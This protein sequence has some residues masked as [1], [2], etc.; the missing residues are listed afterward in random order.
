MLPG[1]NIIEVALFALTAALGIYYI[2]STRLID[3][4]VSVIRALHG[5]VR[6]LLAVVVTLL[7]FVDLSVAE[8]TYDR[9]IILLGFFTIIGV[10]LKRYNVNP[11]VLL[12]SIILS[13]KLIWLYIQVYNINF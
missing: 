13:D 3:W 1:F 6:W 11:I 12:F 7:I 10:I 8:I 4:Y 5:N 2:L 9:Y